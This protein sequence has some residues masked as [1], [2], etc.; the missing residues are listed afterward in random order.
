[1][2]V[3]S[4]LTSNQPLLVEHLPVEGECPNYGVG[5]GVA[6][7]LCV[8]TNALATSR[9]RP[10]AIGKRPGDPEAVPGEASVVGEMGTARRAQFI[11]LA[12][13][14]NRRA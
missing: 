5:V 3:D 6:P 12:F 2:A 14:K 8:L 4:W 9:W 13:S 10:G 11:R 1:M 7:P